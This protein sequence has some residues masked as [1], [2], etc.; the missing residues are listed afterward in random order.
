MPTRMAQRARKLVEALAPAQ[1][2]FFNNESR[3]GH[4]PILG[5]ARTAKMR[6]KREQSLLPSVCPSTMSAPGLA[7]LRRLERAY[8]A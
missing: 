6:A 1:H 8:W 5:F 4:R 7:A 3:F 2:P